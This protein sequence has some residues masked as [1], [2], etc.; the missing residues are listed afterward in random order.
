MENVLLPKRYSSTYRGL[1]EVYRKLLRHENLERHYTVLRDSATTVEQYHAASKAL[2]KLQ[3]KDRWKEDPKSPLFDHALLQE[4]IRLL[5]KARETEELGNIIFL[6]RT[7]LSRNIGDMGNPK[8]LS[9][10]LYYMYA[11]DSYQKSRF[12]N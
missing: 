1:Q 12:E 6:L 10:S 8:V 9:L 4:R 5:K 3:G 2:D 11:I 7:S